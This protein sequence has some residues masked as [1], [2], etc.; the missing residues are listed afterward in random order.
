MEVLLERSME[1]LAGTMLDGGIVP[2]C[3]RWRHVVTMLD[4]GIDSITLEGGVLLVL[5]EARR[6]HNARG[7]CYVSWCVHLWHCIESR[8]VLSCV[9]TD[10]C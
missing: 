5:L 8:Y 6:D 3:A 10:E 4:G 1:V 2:L 7:R 9:G